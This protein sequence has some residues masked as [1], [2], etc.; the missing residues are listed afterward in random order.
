MR[1]SKYEQETILLT[2]EEDS[3]WDIFTYN[4][5]LQRKLKTFARKYP[6]HCKIGE[7]NGTGGMNFIIDKSRVTIRLNPPYSEERRAVAGARMKENRKA[8]N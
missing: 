5:A 1:L 7:D 2:N 4:K 8:L 6:E 3:T